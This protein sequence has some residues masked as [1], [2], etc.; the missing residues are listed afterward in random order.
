VVFGSRSLGVVSG[1][2]TLLILVFSE[3]LPKTIGSLHWRQLAPAVGC[4][5]QGLQHALLPFVLLSD[6]L[7]R[8]V[9]RGRG[10][11]VF[12]RDEFHALA[13]LGGELGHLKPRETQV[14]ANLLH[15]RSHCVREIM[16]PR[17]VVFGLPEHVTVGQVM[18][19]Y[20]ELP[21]SRIPVFTEALD[22]SLAFVLRADIL[23]HQARRKTGVRLGDLKRALRAVPSSNSLFD[24]LE[25]LL[26]HQEHIALVVDEYGG[27]DGIVTLEDV[28]ETLVGLEIVDEKDVAVDMQAL[29]RERWRRHADRLGVDAETFTGQDGD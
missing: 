11:G 14:L 26:E 21:F 15:F 8:L 19:H 9:S 3:I 7:T 4:G 17:T 22:D 27:M 20:R 2:L 16:T 25:L 23:L 5:V 6:L 29:A 1:V 13:L 10:P 28:V 24:T 18:E 12:H